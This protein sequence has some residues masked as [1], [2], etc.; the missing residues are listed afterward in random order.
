MELSS[1]ECKVP[2]RRGQSA[3]LTNSIF[4]DW[5]S[6]ISILAS[7]FFFYF[8]LTP[9]MNVT[10][11]NSALQSS[12]G[13]QKSWRKLSHEFFILLWHRDMQLPK[14]FHLHKLIDLS[15]KPG[16]VI[17]TPQE[18]KGRSKRGSDLGTCTRLE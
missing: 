8:L 9:C 12:H 4:T 6:F 3:V 15:W 11:L 1:L 14:A 13:K 17:S 7:L 18:R 5:L 16:M 2:E 10:R